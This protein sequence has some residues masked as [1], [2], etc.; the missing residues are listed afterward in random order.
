MRNKKEICVGFFLTLAFAAGIWFVYHQSALKQK[1]RSFTLNAYFGQTDGLMSGAP[2]RVAGVT[3]GKVAGQSLSRG[4]RVR[5]ELSFQRPVSL[6]VDSSVS[7]ETD[8]LLGKKYVEI[9]P[10][11]EDAVLSSGEDFSFTQDSLI[12]GELMNKVN[13]YM[14]VKKNV[15]EENP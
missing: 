12:L 11:A 13:G 4:Y 8:G 5:A 2:V 15:L 3:V 6:P 7:I 1:I 10:G 9:T 14:R